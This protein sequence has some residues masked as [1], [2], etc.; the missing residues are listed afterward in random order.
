LV[1]LVMANPLMSAGM[2]AKMLE[3]T[4]QAARRIVAELGLRELPGRRR[5]RAWGTLK[6]EGQGYWCV[7]IRSFQRL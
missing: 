5:F 1:E 3:V 6:L 2:V 4:P 7:Y